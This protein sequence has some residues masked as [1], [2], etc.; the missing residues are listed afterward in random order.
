MHTNMNM[1]NATYR[2]RI[3]EAAIV[4]L[5]TG[6]E[7]RLIRLAMGAD[8][9]TPLRP[10]PVV[11]RSALFVSRLVERRERRWL[12]AAREEQRV[13]GE[14][15]RLQHREHH[16]IAA[17]LPAVEL[18]A[19]RLCRAAQEGTAR[20]TCEYDEGK[21]KSPRSPILCPP[22][23]HPSRYRCR[24]RHPVILFPRP[25]AHSRRVGI[26]CYI[27]VVLHRGN[28]VDRGRRIE[29]VRRF[30]G[31]YHSKKGS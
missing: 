17:V 12:I 19:P 7:A 18:L 9:G 30:S 11:H 25:H 5:Q 13:V 24:R 15:K 10:R 23:R 20:Q 6:V 1:E 2:G 3:G 29:T 4:K 27:C 28:D 26:I 22:D 21:V 8:E 31:R 16:L 14:E